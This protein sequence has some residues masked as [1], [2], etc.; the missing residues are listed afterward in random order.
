[1]VADT[2]GKAALTII[3][4]PP[5]SIIADKKN[6]DHEPSHKKNKNSQD[7]LKQNIL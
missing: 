7:T 5:S 3:M 2:Q 6:H 1:M 4:P